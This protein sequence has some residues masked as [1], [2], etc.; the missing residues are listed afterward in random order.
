MMSG[1][2]IWNGQGNILVVLSLLSSC[3]GGTC[4]QDWLHILWILWAT[5][6]DFRIPGVY[7]ILPRSFG[8][9][10]PDSEKVVTEK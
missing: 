6:T 9:L 8:S 10:I 5:F 4:Y 7:F 3:K 2:L 1:Y